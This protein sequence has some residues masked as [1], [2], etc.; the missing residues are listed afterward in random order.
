[1][2]SRTGALLLVALAVSCAAPAP[3]G[4][5]IDVARALAHVDAQLAIGPRPGETRASAQ[6]LA[7]IEAT[8]VAARARATR[9]PVGRVEIPAIVVLGQTYRAAH[10]A[11]RDDP[12]L[13]VRF[14][15]PPGPRSGRALLVMAHYDSVRT[16]PGA[17]DNAAAVGV[18][19]E[20]ARALVAAPPRQPVILAFTANEE[21]GLVGAEALAAEL[22]GEVGFA[23][24]LDL[25]GG[26][27]ALSV[28][29]AGLLIGASEL[30]WLAAAADASGIALRV[31]LPHRVVSRWWPQAERS[32]H[33]P[34]TRRGIRAVHLYHRGQDGEW[35]DRAYHGPGDVAARVAPG[36]LADLGRLLRALAERPLPHLAEGDGF[37]VPVAHGLIVPRG[38]LLAVELVLAALALLAV[39]RIRDPRAPGPGLAAGVGCLLAALLAAVALEWLAAGDHPAPWLHAPARWLAGLALVLAGGVGLATR[40]AAR[41]A[42]WAGRGR[43]L[44]LAIGLPLVLGLALVFAGAGEL[45]WVWLVP[46]AATAGLARLVPRLPLLAAVPLG[47]PAAL[48]LYPAQ[49]REAAWNGFWPTAVPLAVWLAVLVAPL[50]AAVAWALRGRTTRGPLGTLVLPVGCALAMLLGAGLLLRTVPACSPEQFHAFHLACEIGP[51]LP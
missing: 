37:A 26:S 30:G 15:P 8:L 40:L 14:G 9:H 5:G 32:D 39:V 7:W 23:I 31:P 22:A 28:N 42:P 50:L 20:L 51:A 29:G 10:T 21:V 45:A 36:S 25:V 2:L 27:G 49:L 33:G 43:Y 41:V 3:A 38:L 47:L 46:A 34:F 48:V 44:Q 19:L 6:T 18:L 4:P 35:I 1:M 13:V 12:N 17:V 16:T 11:T 24:S